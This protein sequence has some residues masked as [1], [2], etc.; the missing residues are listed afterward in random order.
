MP[1]VK[2]IE[3]ILLIDDDKD[4]QEIFTIAVQRLNRGITCYTADDGD[5]GLKQLNNMLL[6][7]DIIFLDLNMPRV[8][9]RQFLQE[10]K[11]QESLKYI[12]VIIYSTSSLQ[13]DIDETRK[14]GAA[15]FLTKP[16]SLT[17]LCE[18][19]TKLFLHETL[20]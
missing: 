1:P 10:I 17:E 8:D 2:K 18:A 7:P 16:Y 3:T 6:A 13:R 19:L 5:E 20:G 11:K 12:P 4:D 15:G 9:G 14:L